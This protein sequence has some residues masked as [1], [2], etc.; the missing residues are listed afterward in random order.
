MLDVVVINANTVKESDSEK[1]QM[2][3]R[4]RGGKPRSHDDAALIVRIGQIRREIEE[5]VCS[6]A[7]AEDCLYRGADYP[8]DF[9]CSC[10]ICRTFYPNRRYPR[11]VRESKYS[12]DCQVEADEDPEFAEEFARLRSDRPRVGSVFFR[13]LG[14]R[15]DTGASPRLPKVKEMT[16][17]EIRE[18][19]KSHREAAGSALASLRQRCERRPGGQVA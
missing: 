11:P 15:S 6:A 19:I 12:L 4:K 16:L 17:E 1:G 9:Q 3:K 7:W 2:R 13:R 5:L 18:I 14:P 8:P 10:A